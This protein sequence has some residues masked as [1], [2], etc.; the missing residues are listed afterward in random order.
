MERYFNKN[1]LGVGHSIIP[2]HIIPYDHTTL[3]EW[4][5]IKSQEG[6]V[7]TYHPILE[8]YLLSEVPGVEPIWDRTSE[9]NYMKPKYCDALWEQIDVQKTQQMREYINNVSRNPKAGGI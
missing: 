4:D 2:T 8:G 1:L 5:E 7:L 6:F 9:L 3:K